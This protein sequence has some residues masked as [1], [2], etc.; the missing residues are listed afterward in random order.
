MPRDE[1]DVAS[2]HLSATCVCVGRGLLPQGNRAIPNKGSAADACEG[3][4]HTTTTG[5]AASKRS[6]KNLSAWGL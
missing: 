4:S 3:R 1:D 2:Q 5:N 6:R